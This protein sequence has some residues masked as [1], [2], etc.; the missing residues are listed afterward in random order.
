MLNTKLKTKNNRLK[1]TSIQN[2]LA[3]HAFFFTLAPP[4][5]YALNLKALIKVWKVSWT[6]QL[7]YEIFR[8]LESYKFLA[9]LEYISKSGLSFGHSDWLVVPACLMNNKVLKNSMAGGKTQIIR[10]ANSLLV[11]FFE[12]HIDMKIPY[13][14]LPPLPSLLLLCTHILCTVVVLSVA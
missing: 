3:S 6:S 13:E 5:G 8:F 7:S 1:Q 9:C 2:T 10:L 12:Y 11:H 14:N 4:S